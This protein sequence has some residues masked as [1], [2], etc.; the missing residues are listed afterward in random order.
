MFPKHVLVSMNYKC[1][2]KVKLSLDWR[3]ARCPHILVMLVPVQ[4]LILVWPNAS[5]P[6][7]LLHSQ[8]ENLT[9]F[10][11]VGCMQAVAGNWSTRG[12]TSAGG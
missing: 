2:E 4:Q 3:F 11:L 9:V 5:V 7:G 1:E 8:E 10:S 12:T 6:D